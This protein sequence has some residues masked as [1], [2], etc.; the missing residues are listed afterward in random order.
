MKNNVVSLL[1]KHGPGLASEFIDI[2]TESGLSKA[3]ARQRLTR[4]KSEYKR[5]AGIRFAHNT[6]FIYLAK[7]HGSLQFW[8]AVEQSFESRGKAY[9]CAVVGLRSRGGLCFESQFPAICGAPIYRKNQ[10]PPD[11]ILERL[12]KI[13]LLE[14]IVVENGQTIIQFRPVSYTKLSIQSINANLLAEFVALR[15]VLDWARKI[16]LGSYNSFSVRGDDGNEPVVSSITWDLSAPSYLRPLVTAS[17]GKLK[18]GFIV[19]DINF[20]GQ[21]NTDSVSL[22]IRKHD[23]ASAPKNVAPI[24]PM[25]VGDK[26]TSEAFSLARSKGIVAAT[27]ENLFGKSTAKSLRDLIELVTNTGTKISDKPNKLYEL[28][29]SLT[30]IEGAANNIR[31]A[32]FE[33]AIG[34]L[35]KEIEG[36]DLEIGKNLTDF[37][38]NRKV[39][40]DVLLARS[41]EG[42]ISVIECKSKIPGSKVSLEEVQK[43]YRDRVPLI[44]KILNHFE[45]YRCNDFQFELWTNG[46]FH[47]RARDWL[48]QQSKICE[49]YNVDWKDGNS[50]REYA[51]QG[52]S[53]TLR[54]IL[55]EHYFRHPLAKYSD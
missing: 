3:A 14:R 44:F 26:F 54:N 19:C 29:S 36:G 11:L 51:K 28:L 38:S 48:E 50:L 22:F 43:W 21:V 5:L 6:R 35:V 30:K 18:P 8:G 20:N 34:Y 9:W 4:A 47:R 25:F 12:I 33:F 53:G 45:V 13:H 16:G 32:L 41:D 23:M 7:Q 15:A 31:G 39:E 37:E 49:G 1:T 27:V 46:N 24:L 2:M 17:T 52:Q 40:I 55:D 10:L 42:A